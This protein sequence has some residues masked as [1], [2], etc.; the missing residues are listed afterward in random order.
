MLDNFWRSE[1]SSSTQDNVITLDDGTVYAV[2]IRTGDLHPIVGKLLPG[3][4]VWQTFDLRTISGDPFGNQ[5][6]D[7]H[8]T[9]SLGIGSDGI[10]HVAGNMH[11]VA[12]KY[13]RSTA[14]YNISAWTTGSMV[15]TQ[16]TSVTYPLFANSASGALY[17]FYRQG[18]SGQGNVYMNKWNGVGS[19]WARM[20]T[21]FDGDSSAES[22]YINRVAPDADG[23]FHF[24]VTWREL[25]DADS[26]TDIGYVYRD[27]AGVWRRSDGFVQTMPV[28]HANCEIVVPMEQGSGLINQTGLDVDRDGNPHGVFMWYDTAGKSQYYHVWFEADEWHTEQVSSFTDRVETI[29]VVG[30]LQRIVARPPIVCASNGKVYVIGRAR[31]TEGNRPILIDCTAPGHPVTPLFD[32]DLSEWEAAY[33]FRT[34][35]R[36]DDLRM[37]VTDL[38]SPAT[39]GQGYERQWGGILTIDLYSAPLVEGG[40]PRFG[41]HD[42]RRSMQIAMR[43][44][45]VASTDLDTLQGIDHIGS[46]LMGT[47]VS[48]VNQPVYGN[49]RPATL[50]VQKP[51]RS[52]TVQ[53]IVDAESQVFT[54]NCVNGVW[55]AWTL[56]TGGSL[57]ALPNGTTLSTLWHGDFFLTNTSAYPGEPADFAALSPAQHGV[58]EVRLISSSGGTNGIKFYR[59]TAF[60][61]SRVWEAT[62]SGGTMSSWVQTRGGQGTAAPSTTPGFVG[63]IF[64]DTTAKKAYIATGTSSSADWTILN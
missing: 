15:G 64:T 11:G 56:A 59:L 17:F 54:R 2:W 50:T 31:S 37:L 32:M 18:T 33:D 8:N 57:V 42:A 3:A 7:G 35:R 26:N 44:S 12:L 41:K 24:M 4:T 27:P 10:I 20:A 46:W 9:F 49:T 58:L 30:T 43:G 63:Q 34:L 5:T 52:V 22:P 45:L 13:A 48:L 19:G 39:A 25:A 40:A 38:E 29:G 62:M 55:T 6:P 60:D 14:A 16:E 61:R 28:T 21:V 1:Q 47:G 36:S 53:T 51:H 23:G